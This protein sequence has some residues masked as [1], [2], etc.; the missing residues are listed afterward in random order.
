MC[1][2]RFYCLFLKSLTLL[3]CPIDKSL[4]ILH[5]IYS[6]TDLAVCKLTRRLM[7]QVRQPLPVHLVESEIL[8]LLLLKFASDRSDRTACSIRTRSRSNLLWPIQEVAS[9][10]PNRVPATEKNKRH[11]HTQPHKLYEYLNKPRA[12]ARQKIKSKFNECGK[13]GCSL[14]HIC[15]HN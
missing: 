7:S 11:T 4:N 15:L 5:E 14:F 3:N 1:S 8:V 2:V 12:Y 10:T 13:V 6:A 9:H